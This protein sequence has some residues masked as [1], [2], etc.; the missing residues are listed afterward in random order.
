MAQ[1]PPRNVI[2][3]DASTRN[4]GWAVIDYASERRLASGNIP[5]S[6]AEFYHRLKSGPSLIIRALKDAVDFETVRMLV[7]EHSFFTK[8]PNTGKLLTMMI[9]AIICAVQHKGI[10]TIMEYSPTTI[11]AVFAGYGHAEK[12]DIRERVAMEFGINIQSEDECDALAAAQAYIIEQKTGAIQRKASEKKF[13][14]QVKTE[15]SARTRAAKS[16][17]P[18]KGELDLWN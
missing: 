9:G 16:G 18:L 2:G 13:K 3:I 11:K 8:N 7:I 12:S 6:E 1:V 4:I 17:K 10:S 5:L 14:Q 15:K